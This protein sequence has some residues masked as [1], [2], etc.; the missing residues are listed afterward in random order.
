MPRKIKQNRE[1]LPQNARGSR[2]CLKTTLP[3]F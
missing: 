1:N 3:N 2:I